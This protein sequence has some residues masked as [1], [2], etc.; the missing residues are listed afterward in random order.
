MVEIPPEI[1]KAMKHCVLPLAPAPQNLGTN[2]WPP[3]KHAWLTIPTADIIYVPGGPRGWTPSATAY[4]AP[5]HLPVEFRSSDLIFGVSSKKSIW[6]TPLACQCNSEDRF[7]NG[8]YCSGQWSRPTVTVTVT[9][10]VTIDSAPAGQS[11]WPSRWRCVAA[12]LKLDH[13]RSAVSNLYCQWI[14]N[15]IVT[16]ASNSDSDE[17]TVTVAGHCGGS[18]PGGGRARNRARVP[19]AH[20]SSIIGTVLKTV[21]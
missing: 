11:A 5:C 12:A 13:I 9:V 3:E 2:P 8:R 7:G 17:C 15:V 19:P 10:T 4:P 20:S 16:S 6:K 1:S 18:G 21:N 14:V